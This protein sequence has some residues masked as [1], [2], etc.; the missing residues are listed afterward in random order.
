MTHSERGADPTG[1]APNESVARA[2]NA[3]PPR[4][5]TTP[6]SRVEGLAPAAIRCL[7]RAAQGIDQRDLDAADA[8]LRQAAAMAPEHAEILRLTGVVAVQIGNSA[9]TRLFIRMLT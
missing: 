9:A 2:V 7:Q 8:A 3:P 4:Q 6:A 1:G 5:R